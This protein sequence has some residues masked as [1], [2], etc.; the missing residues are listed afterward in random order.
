MAAK[1]GFFRVDDNGFKG[2][3]NWGFCD[4]LD[5]GFLSARMIQEG[6]GFM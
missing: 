1:L 4:R 5:E 3:S 6:K 2:F